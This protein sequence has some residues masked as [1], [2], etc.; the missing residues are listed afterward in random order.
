MIIDNEEHQTKEVYALYG[1][2]MYYAQCCEKS[3]VM[4]LS[5]AWAS[6]VDQMITDDYD[7]L[8]Q[9]NMKKTFGSLLKTLESE[10][11][12]S[13]ELT[14]NIN[15][16]LKIRNFLAHDYFWDRAGEFTIH[17]GRTKMVSELN[18]YIDIFDELDL[19][20]TE[21]SDNWGEQKG[22]TEEMKAECM[23]KIIQKAMHDYCNQI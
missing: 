4:L 22:V 9:V 15:S 11:K 17:E 18:K 10:N 20:L 19:K 16:V 14:E 13:R 8:L 7:K 2:A 12:I 23:N 6:Q 1:L 3:L 5:S 21:I